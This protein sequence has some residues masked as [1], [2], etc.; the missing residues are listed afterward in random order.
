MVR[1]KIFFYERREEF[2]SLTSSVRK[3]ALF[4]YLNRHCFNGLCRYNKK[5]KYNVPFGT[6]NNVYLPEQ[7]MRDIHEVLQNAT[8]QCGNAFDLIAQATTGD[9]VYCDPPY[10]PLSDTAHFTKYATEG[11]T[12]DDQQRLAQEANAATE[13]GAT[14][15]IS[16]HDTPLAHELY[17]DH[18]VD[19]FMVTRTISRGA[20]NPAREII[21][22]YEPS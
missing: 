20:R 17:G 15:I 18:I 1:I 19:S 13:R 14:V 7:E 9:V 3:S 8:I 2:N 10:L 12:L 5:G 6:C 22:K 4:I 21:A 16:N 11:F